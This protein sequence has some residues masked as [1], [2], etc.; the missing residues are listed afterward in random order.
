MINQIPVFLLGVFICALAL[1]IWQLLNK[2]RDL[3]LECSALKTQQAEL[4]AKY[5]GKALPNSKQPRRKP[6][7]NRTNSMVIRSPVRQLLYQ[8]DWA[9]FGQQRI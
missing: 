9:V 8:I 5:F 2:T 1:Y 4:K 3:Q 7:S 6:Q